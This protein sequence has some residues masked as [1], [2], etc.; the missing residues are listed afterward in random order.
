MRAVVVDR[1]M[2]PAE[3]AVRELPDPV[4]GPGQLGVDVKAAGCNFFDILIVQ[5]RYQVKPPFPF[6]PGGEIAGVVREIG[7][8]VAKPSDHQAG[9]AVGDR[10]LASA[11]MGGYADRI[12]IPASFAHRM[13]DAMSFEEGAA[14][15]IVYPTSYA[16]LVY[17]AALKPGETLLVHAAAGGVGLAA[18]QIGKALGARVIATA[19][20]PDK[21]R[22][23]IEAGAEFGI[24]YNS[25]DFVERVKEITGGKGADVIYDSVGGEIFD[26]SLKCIAWCGRLLVIGFAG[27]TIPSVA[28]N[29][30]LLKNVSVVGL[31]WGAYAKYEPARIP[32]TFAALFQL[33][34][35]KKIRP[36]IY[37]SYPLEK[38]ADALA[39][40][41]S[42]KTHGKVVLV[43]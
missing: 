37:G 35:E 13:P 14:L 28:A 39:A 11:P 42:R 40:L 36:V 24:D 10:V 27:G 43:P 19:G 41:G 2:E 16:G 32:E 30:I 12:A 25:E 26:K 1:W 20:G 5:G 31:H 22:V 33:Y 7:P 29:R 21:V 15:P 38:A 6:I 3:L 34:E 23:A 8:G 18:V 4:V 9:F 17:R